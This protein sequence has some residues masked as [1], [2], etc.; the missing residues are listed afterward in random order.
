MGEF[1]TSFF[2][3]SQTVGWAVAFIV[4]LIIEAA[5]SYALISIWFA[6]GALGALLAAMNNLGFTAQL[7]VFIATSAILLIATK[8]LVK[9]LKGKSPIDPNKDY[10]L[11]RSATVIEAIDNNSGVGRVRLNGT[12]WAAVS[13][14]GSPIEKDSIVT[15]SKVDGAK[16][17]VSR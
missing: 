4:F 8:P 9:K 10:D 3:N 15:V 12:D 17:I 2:S 11:G 13:A 14:D 5:T 16:L 6:F 7:I 1:L